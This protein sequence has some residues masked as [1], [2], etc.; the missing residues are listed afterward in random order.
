M[1]IKKFVEKSID[2]LVFLFTA[3]IAAI[4]VVATIVFVGVL[5]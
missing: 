5:L 4:A 1:S 2:A 3:A